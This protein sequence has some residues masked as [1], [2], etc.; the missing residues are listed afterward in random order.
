MNMRVAIG[1]RL[2]PYEVT[3]MLGA[4]G[5][6]EVYKAHD[7]RLRRDVALKVLRTNNVR[8]A[9]GLHR[10]EQE[11][12]AAS[13]LKHPNII[14]IYDVGSQDGC[15]YI[16]SELLEG[17]PLSTPLTSGPLPVHKAVEY[18]IQIAAGLAAAHEKGVVHR[19]LKPGNIFLP[20]HDSVKILDFGLA[21][22]IQA[23]G[24]SGDESGAATETLDTPPERILGTPSYMS[25][26]QVRRETIDHRSDI[27]SFGTVLYEMLTGRRPFER[28]SPTE[29]MNA[30]VH[31]DPPPLADFVKELRPGIESIVGHCLE[32]KREDRFQSARDLQF[33]LET[34][35]GALL[36]SSNVVHRPQTRRTFLISAGSAAPGIAAGIFAG[37]AM[38]HR[39]TPQFQRLTFQ[40]GTVRSA[41]FAPDD[42]TILYSA[43]WNGEPVQIYSV[44]PESPES[45]PLGSAGANLLAISRSGELAI[46]T[47]YHFVGG[48]VSSG[49][50]A[51][52]PMGGGAPR[53]IMEDVQ[54]ADWAPDGG[55]AM[56][57]RAAGK[58][59]LE[60]PAGN[61][62]FETGGWIGEV[63]FSPGGDR[64]AFIDHP[65]E[66]NNGGSIATVD[67]A[68]KRKVLCGGF[69]AVEGL[70][71]SR[72]G[73]EI[74]F[75]GTPVGDNLRLCATALSG[76]V[77]ELARVPGW[78]TIAD[79]SRSGRVLMMHGS[80]RF[81]MRAHGPYASGEK[82]ISWH[83]WSLLRDISRD[84]TLVLFDET[85]EGGGATL[86]AYAR[87]TDGSPAMR[88]GRGLAMSL[89][90]D[91]QWAV[92]LPACGEP[93]IVLL[94]IGPGE[95]KHIPLG[96]NISAASAGWFP[97]GKRLLLAASEPGRGVRFYEIHLGADLSATKPRPFSPEGVNR[98]F[99]AISPD[100]KL[101]IGSNL[102]RQARIHV[103]D[104]GETRPAPGVAL[105]ELPIGWS[106][107]PRYYYVFSRNRLPA[108]I[109]RIE[110][111]SGQRELWK[112]I[113]PDDPTGINA[114]S[115]IRI[116]PNGKWY[117]YS[118][119]SQLTDL[120][121]V[122]GLT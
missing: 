29:T 73:D 6:G 14:T 2:G 42:R 50:L 84:G 12:R 44:R 54:W 22:I 60:Y 26:E 70:A 27:F 101:V 41:R 21:K 4:G 17:E 35:S 75:T 106:D 10:F 25:P 116:S 20:R 33:S 83:D 51:R 24:M 39:E 46:A 80:I 65:V 121:L 55:L 107:D 90:P 69:E 100:G 98:T 16:I 76:R 105:G 47:R 13:A 7:R 59:R 37:K 102:D 113:M 119:E 68:G 48:F 85:G 112:E 45:T 117:A 9:E 11:A 110:L 81:S 111:A 108:Q 92:T 82:N 78:N 77:R 34:F 1:S 23:S 36:V 97:D 52:A 72:R 31:D 64:I 19:D 62:L 86:G 38:V 56:V 71:W 114:V 103:V 18:A 74:W 93:E 88:L 58:S 91:N 99:Y 104:T 43:S 40:R 89:S 30:I 96:Q 67:L 79:V 3:G 109:Y 49:T 94:P 53:E 15:A 28:S 118:V 61:V 120:Y 8:T 32:K 122:D 63:R 57:H 66:G 5:M 115:V 95:P 87:K